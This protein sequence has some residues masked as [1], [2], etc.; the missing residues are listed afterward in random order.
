MDMNN[1]DIYK[2][3]KVNTIFDEDDNQ[4]LSAT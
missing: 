4:D 1:N 2:S 3:A